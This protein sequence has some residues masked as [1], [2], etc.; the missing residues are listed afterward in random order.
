MELFDRSILNVLLTALLV[1]FGISLLATLAARFHPSARRHMWII[2]L[3]ILAFSMLGF[4]TGYTMALSREPA[5][6]TVIPAVLAL[7]GG[8]AVYIVGSKGA[9]AQANVS[10]MALCFTSALLLGALFGTQLRTEVDIASGDPSRVRER[11]LALE[12][13]RLAVEVQRLE[14]Y[15]EFLKMKAQFADK[16]KL[17]LSRFESGFERQAKP[18][19]ETATK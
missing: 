19:Q 14:N 11:E 2:F 16:E 5:V 9:E 17:D 4:V 6:G 8:V 1:S 10:S 3:A 7:L 12:Q 18:S 13:V 15:I